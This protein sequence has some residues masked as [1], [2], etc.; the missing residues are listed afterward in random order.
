MNH[1]PTAAG[2]Q[3][4]IGIPGFTYADLYIPDRLRELTERFYNSVR[5]SDAALWERFDHYRETLGEGMKPEDVSEVIVDITPHLS[6]FISELFQVRDQHGRMKHAVEAETV[7][8]IFKREFVARRALKKY[9][10]VGTIAIAAVR[11]EVDALNRLAFG[12]T[13]AAGDPERGTATVVVDLLNME[14]SLKGATAIDGELARD[15]DNL[16][17]RVQEA[18]STSP[19]LAGLLP[20][21]TETAQTETLVTALLE[22]YERWVAVEHYLTATGVHN[23]VSLRTP[24][25]IDYAHLVPI[26]VPE[27]MPPGARIGP[28]EHLRYRDGF[29]LTDD[30]YDH[31]EVMN[32]VEYCIY[33]HNR[34]K[35]SCSKGLREKDGTKKRNPLGVALHGC[36]LDEKISEMHLLKH[37]GDGLGALAIVMIDNPM[38]PGTGHRICNDCMKACI[39]QK[40]DPVNIPQIE[41]GVLTEV[42]DYPY[43][44][45]IYSLLT[46]WNPLNVRRP[47]ALPYNGR[48]ILVVG[49]GPAGYTLAHYLI[50]EGFG[51]VG[52]DGLKIEPLAEHLTGT[53]NSAPEPVADWR[54]EIYDSLQSRVLLGFGGVSE[55]GITVR[56]DKNF[57]KVIYIALARRNRFK[58]YGGVRFGGTI[59]IEDAWNLGFDHIAIATGAGKPTIV[60]M[61][62]NLL[63]GVRQASDFLMALQLTGAFK[64]KALANLQVRLPA[65]II[66]GGLTGID[67]T[68]ELM[69]YYPVQVERVLSR[70]RVLIAERGEEEFWKLFNDEETEAL[71]EFIA[72]GE[73]IEAE[74]KRAAEE[75]RAPN[76]ID[77]IRGWGGVSLVY[78]KTMNDAPAY[79]LNHEEIIKA[80]E[81]GIYFIENLSPVEAVADRHGAVSAV[82]FERQEMDEQ[83]KWRGSRELITMPARSVMVAAGTS[84]NT[85]IERENPGAFAYDKWNQFFAP[86]VTCSASDIAAMET[87]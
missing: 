41:T 66:G 38:C 82:V 37:N 72:H 21:I 29:E 31:R 86:F 44:F 22:L 40:Q 11:E 15:A 35:D 65:V 13:F 3:L 5:E 7:I 68:T 55:Y 69:A 79:R 46:R 75:H 71:K 30:R 84:P 50:N 83:G 56:W 17:G 58:F 1:N 4:L 52:I 73:A 77:M 16:I 20:E 9:P 8:F 57:L 42:L 53:K 32:E 14:K 64:P 6:A 19:L 78:R 27:N 80:L 2:T 25:N 76:F 45:E 43:G 34:D 81:E 28:A 70:S 63:R 12:A 54:A 51:V 36:P 74:R 59:S 18:R 39:Y 87:A 49:L 26:R 24:H 67:T 47:Y 23:W 48:K 33:C 85:I 62:N 61:K 60:P 10:N